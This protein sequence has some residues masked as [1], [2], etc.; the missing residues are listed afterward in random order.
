MLA[1]YLA[2][3]IIW[4]NVTTNRIELDVVL[5]HYLVLGVGVITVGIV[6]VRGLQKVREV[7]KPI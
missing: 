3:S 5:R 2:N 4:F 6:S 1:V 7:G